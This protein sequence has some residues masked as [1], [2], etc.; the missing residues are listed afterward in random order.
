MTYEELKTAHPNLLALDALDEANTATNRLAAWEALHARRAE[1][2]RLNR[3]ERLDAMVL[4]ALD[5][6]LSRLILAPGVEQTPAQRVA[7]MARNSSE[8]LTFC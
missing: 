1:I 2:G 5:L 7:A 6:D 8:E 4:R 3:I